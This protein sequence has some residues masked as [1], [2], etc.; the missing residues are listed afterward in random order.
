MAA[1]GSELPL[2]DDGVTI[3]SCANCGKGLVPSGRRTH[4][5]DACK[6]SAYRR[7][8]APTGPVAPLP[9]K[10]RK[11]AMTVYEC[12]SCGARALGLFSSGGGVPICPL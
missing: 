6:Q 2:R 12:S 4:Y 7:R 1:V 3:R 9:A 10:G 11:R 5:G 8:K